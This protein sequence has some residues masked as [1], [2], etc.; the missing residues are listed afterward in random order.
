[1]EATELRDNIYDH[2]SDEYQGGETEGFVGLQ[3]QDKIIVIQNE[4][5]HYV[6]TVQPLAL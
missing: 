3:D 4:G 2:L 6:V 5:Q 1:M